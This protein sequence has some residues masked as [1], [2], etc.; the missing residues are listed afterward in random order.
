[1]NFAACDRSSLGIGLV[2]HVHHVDTA[3]FIEMR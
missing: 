2:T 3:V 1:M